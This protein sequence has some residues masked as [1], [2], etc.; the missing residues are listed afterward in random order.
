MTRKKPVRKT[1]ARSPSLD[2]T[3]RHLWLASLGLLV[4]GRREGRHLL[5]Q[6]QAKAATAADD[7][8]KAVRQAEAGLRGS[9]GTVRQ[10]VEPKVQSLGAEVEARLAPIV[11]KLGLK[12]AGKRAARKAR[13]APAKAVRRMARKPAKRVARKTAR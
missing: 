5:Q 10:Q 12:P 2:A 11:A 9:L 6:A 8:R 1:A 4:A 13:K 7:A 3:P